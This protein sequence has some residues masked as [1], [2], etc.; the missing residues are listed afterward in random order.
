MRV[1]RL[2]LYTPL[3]W[4]ALAATAH[5]NEGLPTVDPQLE[6]GDDVA[7]APAPVPPT[8][9]TA[10]PVAVKPT[11]APAPPEFSAPAALPAA[12]TQADTLNAPPQ[13]AIVPGTRSSA[14]AALPE[15]NLDSRVAATAEPGAE[16]VGASIPE[17]QA[18]AAPIESAAPDE[19]V[20][21]LVSAPNPTSHPPQSTVYQSPQPDAETLKL[22]AAEGIVIPVIP[23]PEPATPANNLQHISPDSFHQ[24]PQPDAE[25]TV[26]FAVPEDYVVTPATRVCQ[27]SRR[28]EA[29]TRATTPRGMMMLAQRAAATRCY[30]PEA[31]E[32]VEGPNSRNYAASPALSIY[33]PVGYG[34]DRNT[35]F[36][37]TNYQS[38]VRPDAE[39]STF[40]G[41]LGVGLGDASQSVGA[42]LS[43]V[44]V[45]NDDFGEGGFNVKLHRR[46]PDDWA[47]AAGWNGL[48]NI[49]RNDF[50]HS[51]YGV[52]TK[53]LRLRPSLDDSF[54]RLSITA[55]LGDNQFRSNGAAKAGENH[56][57]I[58]GNLSLRVARPVS[59]IA[60]WTGQ[61]LGLGL[62]IAPIKSLPLTITPAVR[63]LVTTD[64]RSA[65][66]VLG[67]G[68]AFQF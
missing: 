46:L 14:I 45:N 61:D 52:V 36:V 66:F 60:E 32:N 67:V 10:V 57:N 12:Q 16:S 49:G 23:A 63:D 40:N 4:L 30:E 11:V 6:A 50:E 20:I 43:Y 24:S 62:S 54:S 47:I 59:F 3:P 68:T 8:V 56:L 5:A 31:I 38:A 2:A 51:K 13:A 33:I 15:P 53:V 34:A 21:S 17:S 64:G 37:S 9:V 29:M 42:E 1:S 41:G 25:T 65:R 26:E 7:I 28:S 18:P 27:T 22:A 35:A 19:L 58:F 48:V 39:G 55:G 44:F